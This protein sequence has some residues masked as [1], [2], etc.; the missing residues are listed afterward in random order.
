MKPFPL[1]FFVMTTFYLTEPALANEQVMRVNV[2]SCLRVRD[3]QS[4]RPTGDCLS[5]GTQVTWTGQTRGGYHVV[6][7]TG[8]NGT[9][10]QALL[11]A[12]HLQRVGPATTTVGPG[13]QAAAEV[14]TADASTP[15][16]IDPAPV[17]EAAGTSPGAAPAPPTQLAG[18][19]P[20]RSGTSAQ[21]AR[22]L[23]SYLDQHPGCLNT[24][25]SNRGRLGDRRE[26]VKVV[27]MGY[28]RAT[29]RPDNDPIRAAMVTGSRHDA[30]SSHINRNTSA[31]DALT[32]NA[33]FLLSL[34]MYESAGGRPQFMGPERLA[35]GR[36]RWGTAYEA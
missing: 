34:G 26:F 17:A 20:D 33:L 25:V 16:P 4:R 7:I 18:F 36:T 6:R 31:R 11:F 15:N 10:Q 12:R 32:T 5:N 30:L 21:V 9:Q 35:N 19:N 14:A 13:A 1:F 27:L 28:L 3:V 22:S 2:S 23:D 8:A 29:C 24:R